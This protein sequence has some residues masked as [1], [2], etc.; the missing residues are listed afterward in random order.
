MIAAPPPALATTFAHVVHYLTDHGFSFPNEPTIVVGSST[1]MTIQG[2]PLNGGRP[3][4][5]AAFAL[6]DGRVVVDKYA[7]AYP[8]LPDTINTLL[9]EVLHTTMTGGAAQAP[10]MTGSQYLSN[11][12]ATETAT[13]DL[14]PG[15]LRDEF[16]VKAAQAAGSIDATFSPYRTLVE[17]E[18]VWSASACGCPWRSA[19]AR[20]AR[21]GRFLTPA[22]DRAL[23]VPASRHIQTVTQ[24]TAPDAP[25]TKGQS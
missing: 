10:G 19:K 4:L 24:R 25:S 5:A 22:L 13:L 12:Q 15:L 14:L 2:T 11:E 23:I 8:R 18:R 1:E 9:H 16:H 3:L 17:A 7:A 21:M 20:S 6:P